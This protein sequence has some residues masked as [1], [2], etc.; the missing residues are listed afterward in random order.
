[1]KY[2]II[3]CLVISNSFFSQEIS[4][5][6][7]IIYGQIL[8]RFYFSTNQ[9]S[10]GLTPN[11]RASL[12]IGNDPI[13]SE[14]SKLNSEKKIDLG[15]LDQVI[16]KFRL[17]KSLDK[18]HRKGPLKDSKIKI[19]CS[20]IFFKNDTEAYIYIIT[21]WK[22]I[23]PMQFLFRATKESDGYWCFEHYTYYY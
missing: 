16:S 4:K 19:I 18:E 6:E 2:L 3:I 17:D 13:E 11:K 22:V 5:D 23:K 14:I 12:L 15:K 7:Y 20:N 1:M 8:D 9:F 10:M 21:E